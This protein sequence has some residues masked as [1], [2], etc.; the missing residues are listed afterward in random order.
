V[1]G[2]IIAN[3]D[4]TRKVNPQTE[5]LLCRLLEWQHH[6]LIKLLLTSSDPEAE[7]VLKKGA[8]P[9]CCGPCSAGVR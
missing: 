1:P 2:R 3:R 6:G 7:W 9:A 8:L 4:G 5:E